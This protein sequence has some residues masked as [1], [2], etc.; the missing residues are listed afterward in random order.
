VNADDVSL[1]GFTRAQPGLSY[2]KM[3]TDTEGNVYIAGIFN[4]TSD[5]DPGPDTFLMSSGD[6]VAQFILK[7]DEDGGFI[8]AGALTG[9]FLNSVRDIAVSKM[10]RV[11]VS[12]TSYGG[13]LDP[14]PQRL[15]YHRAR[16]GDGY[17]LLLDRN[18]QLE[19]A[20]TI[21]GPDSQG[22]YC[23]AFDSAGNVLFGGSF[24]NETEIA[25]GEN[26]YTL[27]A[28]AQTSFPYLTKLDETGALVWTKTLGSEG[29]YHDLATGR[30]GAIAVSF[31]SL[32][33]GEINLQRMSP[34]GNTLWSQVI[35]GDGNVSPREIAM[36]IRDNVYATGSF[37]GTI[38]VGTDSHSL[39]SLEQEASDGYTVKLT[40]DGNVAWTSTLSGDTRLPGFLDIPSVDST[41]GLSIDT[42]GNVYTAGRFSGLADMDPGPRT[43]NLLGRFRTPYVQKLD[44]NGQLIWA[45]TMGPNGSGRVKDLSLDQH[46]NIY[47][48]GDLVGL[49]YETGDSLIADVDPGPGVHLVETTDFSRSYLWKLRPTE[50]TPSVMAQTLLDLL[51][52]DPLPS[53]QGDSINY[54][55]AMAIQPSLTPTEFIYW[56]RN[57]DGRLTATELTLRA[58]DPYGCLAAQDRT[59]REI[60]ENVGNITLL[61]VILLTMAGFRTLSTRL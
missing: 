50:G 59:G 28:P 25:I 10:G 51:L 1:L 46:G 16:D 23:V 29:S 7:L 31:S 12:G 21:G 42:D 57:D 33:T 36:D 39:T 58:E 6:Y 37:W 3:V 43:E 19:R 34:D 9:S 52:Q 49:N 35:G 53:F 4:G 14:D 61:G 20:I 13:D 47:I 38:H 24:E 26:S 17:V 11:L 60:V 48:I 30:D 41:V 40:P 44:I 55:E 5:F 32:E 22:A 56:D 45:R 2:N 27:E 15:Q 8:W 54:P 18:G